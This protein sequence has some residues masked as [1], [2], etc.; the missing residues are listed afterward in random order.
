LAAEHAIACTSLTRV[1]LRVLLERRLP[2]QM[3]E[4]LGLLEGIDR[5]A[6]LALAQEHGIERIEC[7][8]LEELSPS[9]ASRRASA[10]KSPRPSPHQQANNQRAGE[11]S[12]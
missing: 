12:P 4:E 9:R 7:D 10:S 11:A 6:L 2:Q 1:Q 5:D 3:L 8:E